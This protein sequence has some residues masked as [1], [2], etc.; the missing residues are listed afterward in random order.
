MIRP[1]AALLAACL[2]VAP[3]TARAQAPTLEQALFEG[4]RTLPRPEARVYWIDKET[5]VVEKDSGKFAFDARNGEQRPIKPLA[6]SPAPEP[7][8]GRPRRRGNGGSATH[9][10][11]AFAVAVKNNDVY[12]TDSATKKERR[13][14]RDGSATIHNGALDWVY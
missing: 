7:A 1:V 5:Y 3:F 14:T 4:G 13:L 12:V 2:L 9:P 6:A 8:Q 10:T 11:G